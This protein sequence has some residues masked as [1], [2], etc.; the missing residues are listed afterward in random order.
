MG[1]KYNE[2]LFYFLSNTWITD[3]IAANNIDPD[4]AR[5]IVFPE[6]V[7]YSMDTE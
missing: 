3:T 1:K 7:R 2:A 6:L 5:A 4:F